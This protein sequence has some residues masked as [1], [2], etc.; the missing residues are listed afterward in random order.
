MQVGVVDEDPGRETRPEAASVREAK[1]DCKQDARRT[2]LKKKKSPE[3]GYRSYDRVLRLFRTRR[4]DSGGIRMKRVFAAFAA[5]L[6]IGG[7]A[8]AVLGNRHQSQAKHQIAYGENPR[9][10]RDGDARTER[11]RENPRKERAF[12]RAGGEADRKGPKNP[13][14]EQ[15]ENRAYPRNY[16]DDRLALKARQAFARNA[17]AAR[18]H[19]SRRARASADTS[20]TA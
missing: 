15:V 5:F 7:V 8:V 2:P 13:V 14:V 4:R 3:R 18:K 16:V 10:E 9:A 12:E 1:R 6:L 19:S 20:W 17:R 11:E